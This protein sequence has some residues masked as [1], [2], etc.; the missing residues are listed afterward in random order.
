MEE[1]GTDAVFRT[2]AGGLDVR[3]FPDRDS[4]GQAAGREA[5]ERVRRA[6][7]ERSKASVV[8][9]AAPSQTEMLGELASDSTIDWSRVVA[10]QMDEYVGL[11]RAAPQSFGRYLEETLFARVRPGEVHLMDGANDPGEEASRY[12]A[13]FADG[14]DVCCMGIGENGHLAFNEPGAADFKDP[15]P[16]RLVE[17][18]HASRAQQVRDGCFPSLDDVPHRALT[19]TMPPLLA[20]QQVV[21]TVPG[22]AK[23][24]AVART[25][26]G[27][28]GSECPASAL[29]HHPDAVLFLDLE[30]WPGESA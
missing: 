21:C 24:D 15:E 7:G 3:V 11:P 25:L 4:M 6:L 5:A 13:L 27:P 20:A 18:E 17:L 16:V 19:L 8:F 14:I 12:A 23:R 10:L 1:H 28:V 26:W 30:S 2:S 9:A 29:Q 22:A